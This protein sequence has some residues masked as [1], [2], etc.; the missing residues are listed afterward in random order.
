[1]TIL[2]EILARKQGE[3]ASLPCID[4][5]RSN[6]HSLVSAVTNISPSLIAEMKPISPIRG[7]LIDDEDIP[8]IIKLYERHAQAISVLCDKAT[9]GGGFELL[10]SIRSQTDLPLLAK[11]FILDIRQI[12][13][14][15]AHGADAI[16]LIAS[17]LTHERLLHYAKQAISLGLDVLLELHESSEIDAADVLIR[18]LGA[19]ERTHLLLGINNRDLKT[20]TIDLKTTR[21]LAQLLDMR[22]SDTFPRISESGIATSEDVRELSSHVQGFLIG[23]AILVSHDPDTFLS[24]LFTAS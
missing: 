17:L 11:D 8:A 9:F 20:Q 5:A 15:A 12:Y 14:A 23:S 3:I 18:S 19:E 16:L 24:S 4:V 1:M 21:T 2:S 7:R 6:R 22:L 13:A 10:A